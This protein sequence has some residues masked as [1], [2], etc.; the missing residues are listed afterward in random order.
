MKTFYNK[1]RK[2][3]I[4]II[5]GFFLIMAIL[6]MVLINTVME[7]T[8][9]RYEILPIIMVFSSLVFLAISVGTIEQLD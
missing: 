9:Y 2:K 8:D 3:I 6:A 7:W 5:A 4:L 1:H